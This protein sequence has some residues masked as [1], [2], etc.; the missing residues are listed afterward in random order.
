[1]RHFA[2]VTHYE[3]VAVDVAQGV[4]AFDVPFRRVEAV[5]NRLGR[6]GIGEFEAHLTPTPGKT[7]QG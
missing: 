7:Q 3:P 5:L 6:S 1:M 4:M 2:H